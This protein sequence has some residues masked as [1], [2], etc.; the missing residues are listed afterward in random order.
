MKHIFRK[1][2]SLVRFRRDVPIIKQDRERQIIYGIVYEPD[3]LDAHDDAMEAEEIEKACHR[4]MLDSQL[5]KKGHKKPAAAK[6]V[7]SYIAP[8]DFEIG[9]EVVKKGSWVMAVK[10]MD[11]KL[12]QG[13]KAGEYT[14]FS[15]AGIGRRTP[16]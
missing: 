15:M 6:V 3:V 13:I 10:V 11:S 8:V 2:E 12:W 7:E 1:K 14:G 9:D 4:F 16:L 5:I